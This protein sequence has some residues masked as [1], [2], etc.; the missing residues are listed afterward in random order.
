LTGVDWSGIR[1]VVDR[2]TE[3]MKVC[4][5]H[6]RRYEYSGILYLDYAEFLVERALMQ[7]GYVVV[8]KDTYYFDGVVYIPP[9]GRGLEG[10][11]TLIS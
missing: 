7:A 5:D 3:L 4:E 8:A 11:L 6:P 10:L 2:V 1:G 9:A